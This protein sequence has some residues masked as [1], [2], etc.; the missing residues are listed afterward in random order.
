MPIYSAADQITHCCC[1]LATGETQP[2]ETLTAEMATVEKVVM[3]C[4]F[5]D[6]CGSFNDRQTLLRVCS[7]Y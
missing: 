5:M 2:A 6:G 7:S 3:S 4:V 1:S